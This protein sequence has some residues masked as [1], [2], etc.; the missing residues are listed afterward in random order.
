VGVISRETNWYAQKFLENNPDLKLRS[1]THHWKEMN[2][3]EIM[4]LLA[5]FLLQGLHQRLDNKQFFP[6]E[7]S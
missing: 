5:S 1:R 6:E 4:K 7:N 3:I 2:R